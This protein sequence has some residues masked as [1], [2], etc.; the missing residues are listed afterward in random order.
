MLSRDPAVPRRDEL[1]DG[2]AVARA[3]GAAAC[4]RTY[5]KYRVG[6]SLRVVHRIGDGGYVAG[7]SFA[8]LDAAYARAAGPGV[9]RAPALDALLWRFPRDR[10]IAGLP[11]VAGPGAALDDL[12]GARCAATRIVAYAAERSATAACAG[13]D[14]DVIAFAKVHAGDGAARER[15]ATE[16]VRAALASADPNLRVPRVLGAGAS[17]QHVAG[18]G[19]SGGED[20]LALEALPGRRLDTLPPAERERGLERLGAALAALHGLRPPAGARFDRFSPDRLAR[21]VGAIATARPEAGPAAAELL[22]ALLARRADAAGPDVCLHGDANPRNALL[23]GDRV[24]LIDLE[25]VAAGPAAADLGHVLAGLLCERAA[26]R[27]PAADEPPLARALL[28]GYARIA[29]LPR[30]ETLA[31]HTAAA[32]LARRALTAINRVRAG[33]LRHLGDQL[34]AAGALVR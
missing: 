29:A 5:A 9:V 15:R 17:A 1:L 14:G 26:G 8:D 6:E 13:P 21:A 7:R 33:D 19:A 32:V 11:L 18:C 31:W 28:R 2:A 25:D 24:S 20:A 27:L 12:V 34:R 4:E 22:A 30:P 10:R 3:I 16:V 23:D